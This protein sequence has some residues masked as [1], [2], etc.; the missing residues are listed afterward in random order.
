ME[1]KWF[2]EVPDNFEMDWTTVV[3]PTGQRCLVMAIDGETKWFSKKGFKLPGYFLS[4]L[5]GGNPREYGFG[6]TVVTM[7][8]CIYHEEM[9]TYFVLD[10][11][12]W[13]GHDLKD[14]KYT[15]RVHYL[16]KE[17]MK[18]QDFRTITDINMFKVVPLYHYN[19]TIEGLDQALRNTTFEVDGIL[20]YKKDTVYH[21][22]GTENVKWIKP[23][24]LPD[25]FPDIAVP[26]SMM[27]EKPDNYKDFETFKDDV[28]NGRI[29]EKKN[30]K[31]KA[32]K[33]FVPNVKINPPPERVTKRSNKNKKNNTQQ[34]SYFGREEDF[35]HHGC[36]RGIIA[37]D[38]DEG[39]HHHGYSRGIIARDQDYVGANFVKGHG[40]AYGDNYSGMLARTGDAFTR[41]IYG[42]GSVLGCTYYGDDRD[43]YYPDYQNPGCGRDNS[44]R[45]GT[46]Q[47]SFRMSEMQ[48]ALSFNTYDAGS[49]KQWARNQTYQMF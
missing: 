10:C 14:L 37:R 27:L 16:K 9:L 39:F 6:R 42:K 8:D 12:M 15:D 40:K 19:C 49:K 29:K 34:Q 1:S 17:I 26:K 20:F 32:N 36:G 28:Q 5:P 23:Y 3:C 2:L 31:K 30:K 41:P 48:S 21:S 47:D 25:I 44:G 46:Q 4:M 33:E 43:Y 13:A 22:G 11:I 38:Q 45:L 7:L 24:M 18:R 35:H